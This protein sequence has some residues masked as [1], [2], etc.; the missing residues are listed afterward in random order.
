MTAAG[1]SGRQEKR[2]GKRVI[3]RRTPIIPLWGTRDDG[4]WADILVVKIWVNEFI[5]VM[6]E[7]FDGGKGSNSFSKRNIFSSRKVARD[8][9]IA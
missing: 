2:R 5:I 6:G 8:T 9:K 4:F 3:N 7:W 1:A